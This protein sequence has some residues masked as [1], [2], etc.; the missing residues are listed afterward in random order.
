MNQKLVRRVVE[1]CYHYHHSHLPGA[2]SALAC[3]KEIVTP[4]WTASDVIILSK[5]HAAAALYAVLETLGFSPDLS[6]THPER[7]PQSGIVTTTG[8]LGHGLPVALGIAYAKKLHGLAGRVC[9]LLGDEE[10]QEGTTWEALNLADTWRLHNLEV[11]VD[12]NGSGA[13]GPLPCD[14]SAALMR[15]FPGRIKFHFTRKGCGVSFL[16]GRDDHKRVLT[17]EEFNQAMKELS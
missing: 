1:I 15:A 13:L 2:L 5:G 3:L 8:S 11:H 10:C 17:Q 4:D 6:K 14:V 7:D 12:A 16:E 9:V